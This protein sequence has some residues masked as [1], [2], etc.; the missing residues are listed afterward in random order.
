[1]S[2]GRDGFHLIEV[3]IT[4]TI[5]GILS[6]ISLPTYLHHLTT[7]R[8]L[9]ATNLLSKL[10]I[11]MEQYH[12]EHDT[13]QNATLEALHFPT[14][15]GEQ[16]YQLQIE[17]HAHQYLLSAIPLG[18]QATRDARCATLTLTSEGEKGQTGAGKREECW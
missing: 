3:L 13:Y 10:A 8:R 12:I 2:K 7:V 6:A 1:M 5:M 17:S 18:S 14:L 15:I 9:E 11:A 4:L 16:T